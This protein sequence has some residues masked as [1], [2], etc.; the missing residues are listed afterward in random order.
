MQ[1][2]NNHFYEFGVFRIDAL[3]RNLYSS[4]F[5]HGP[6][7]HPVQVFNSPRR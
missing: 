2:L 6:C 7:A 4:P 1:L 3:D 5:A